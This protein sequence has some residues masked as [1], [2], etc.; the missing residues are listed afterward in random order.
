M[1]QRIPDQGALW[2]AEELRHLAENDDQA[3]AAQVA[4]HYGVRHV[5]DQAP[6][7]DR[8]EQELQEAARESNQNH[9][10]QHEF[11]TGAA[12][13]RLD[14][15]GRQHRGSRR[16]GRADQAVGAAQCRSDQAERGRA[17]D[18]GDRSLRGVFMA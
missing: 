9:H 4:A 13:R 7:A 2:C 14:R 15:K 5:P 8:A 16:A 6:D 17:Q 1:A 11:R 12:M 3:H 18:A 10:E